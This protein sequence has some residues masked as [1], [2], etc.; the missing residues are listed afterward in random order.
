MR[1]AQARLLKSA[2]L[3]VVKFPFGT[4]ANRISIASVSFII[5][6]RANL[7]HAEK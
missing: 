6:A 7:S 1:R 2:I 3:N 4:D 5:G